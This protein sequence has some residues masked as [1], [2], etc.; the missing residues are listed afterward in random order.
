MQYFNNWFVFVKLQFWGG[1]VKY[2]AK[3]YCKSIQK[4]KK[5]RN[6]KKNHDDEFK[7][8]WL[9]FFRCNYFIHHK[10]KNTFLKYMFF[11]IIYRG[12]NRWQVCFTF[13]IS[14]FWNKWIKSIFVHNQTIIRAYWQNYFLSNLR[15]KKTNNLLNSFDIFF[16]L[17]ELGQAIKARPLSNEIRNQG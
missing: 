1:G 5:K 6:K 4:E 12:I 11:N 8:I 16:L 13:L 2:L 9:F 7:G 15:R 10:F 14:F 3:K 17:Q